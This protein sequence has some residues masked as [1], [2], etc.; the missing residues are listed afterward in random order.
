MRKAFR[1]PPSSICVRPSSGTMRAAAIAIPVRCTYP[2]IANPKRQLKIPHRTRQRSRGISEAGLSMKRF[3]VD[4]S[5]HRRPANTSGGDIR[6]GK[7]LFA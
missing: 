5:L 1:M 7:H 3:A 6:I 2:K 4:G